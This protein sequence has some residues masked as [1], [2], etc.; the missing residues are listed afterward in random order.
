MAAGFSPQHWPFASIKAFAQQIRVP[1]VP[2]VLL[3]AEDQ[4]FADR[5]PLGSHALAGV[6]AHPLEI[7]S[8]RAADPA[9]RITLG[10]PVAPVAFGFSRMAQQAEQAERGGRDR[11]RGQ[12]P[13]VPPLA[14]S[15]M[16]SR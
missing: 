10:Y 7:G 15:S 16:A 11:S 1:A 5:D 13:R 12:L 9:R 3:D 6:G 14:L 8:R 2:R 4:Q